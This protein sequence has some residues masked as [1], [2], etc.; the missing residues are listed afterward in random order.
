MAVMMAAALIVTACSSDKKTAATTSAS[1][2][3]AP[4]TAS[5]RGITATEIKIGVVV[6]D[7]KCIAQFVDFTQ[8]DAQKILNSLV[9]NINKNGGIDGRQVKT[10]FKSLCPLNPQDTA[11]ACTSF[12]D[13]EQV[14]AVI[15]IYDTPPSDGSQQLCVAKDKSTVL[16]DELTT[17]KTIAGATPGLLLTPHIAPER[18][19]KALL[20]LL[21]QKNTL[22]GKTVA[23]LADQNNQDTA[24]KSLKDFATA[25]GVKTGDTAVLTITG[26]DTTAAQ[27]QLDS[28]IEKWRQQGVNALVMSGLLVS[29]K[30]FVEKIRA[31][32]PD[33][34][35]ISDDSGSGAQANDEVKAGKTPNPYEGMITLSGLNDDETF[36]LP[37]VQACV[38][39]YQDATGETVVAPKD[40]K[41][42]PDGKTT[43]TF[44]GL[45]DRCNELS[46]LKQV[47]E[48]AGPNPTNDSWIAAVNNMGKLKVP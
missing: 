8:G 24:Q 31:A 7:F 29:A 34:T 11:A 20:A 26:T 48:K 40:L 18:Q 33:I 10:V 47:L 27:T 43:R 2:S 25:S 23:L 16:I 32:L 17:G 13:D 9:D 45:E 5:F 39:A 6:V 41:P 21:K 46:I 38:K 12:T 37:A 22:S 15:G 44:E 36:Q 35:L 3:N 19:L 14:F 28:F 1:S 30:Q 4:L 42:G